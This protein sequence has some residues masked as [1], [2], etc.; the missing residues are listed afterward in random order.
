MSKTITVSDETFEAL[1]RHIKEMKDANVYPI[2]TVTQS[3]SPRLILNLPDKFL[4][5]RFKGNV[6]SVDENGNIGTI[7]GRSHPRGFYKN[8]KQVFPIIEQKSG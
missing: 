8:E 4:S 3:G 6:F 5:E 1:E 2:A 7:F